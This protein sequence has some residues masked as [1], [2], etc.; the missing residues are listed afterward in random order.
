MTARELGVQSRAI[1][2]KTLG[3]IEYANRSQ[4]M[5]YRTEQREK[6]YGL[7]EENPHESFTARELADRIG[8]SERV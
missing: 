3:V 2:D 7:F 1:D 6:L 5:A 8:D 4:I